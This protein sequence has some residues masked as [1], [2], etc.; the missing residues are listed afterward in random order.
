MLR[1]ARSVYQVSYVQS[2]AV[3]SEN[4]FYSR[5]TIW[6]HR[7]AI[8]IRYVG[9]RYPREQIPYL[10]RGSRLS[11]TI[12]CHSKRGGSD[13]ASTVANL[14]AYILLVVAG[15]GQAVPSE[16]KTEPGEVCRSSNG[17]LVRELGRFES[18]LFLPTRQ[19]SREVESSRGECGIAGTMATRSRLA[20]DLVVGS[21]VTV[22]GK[23]GVVSGLIKPPAMVLFRKHEKAL[24]K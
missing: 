22:T 21:R 18:T 5:L 6:P 2:R 17:V 16:K 9:D 13:S 20:A 14:P 10:L 19:V 12:A 8:P 11:H 7:G 15:Q 3:R 23:K 24:M 1:E 4:V